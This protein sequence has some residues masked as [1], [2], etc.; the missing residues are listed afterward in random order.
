MLTALLLLSTAGLPIPTPRDATFH[1]GVALGLFVSS[2]DPAYQTATYRTF[3]E[4]IRDL[5][6]THVQLVVRG[7]QDD[8]RASE[9]TAETTD[10]VVAATL[11]HAASLG[12][13]TFVMPIVHLRHRAGKDWRGVLAPTDRR[14]WWRSYRRFVFRYARMPHVDLLAIGSELLTMERDERRWRAL[15]AD[16]RRVYRGQL[17]YSANWDH[18]QP[19]PFWDA[20][21]VVGVNAYPS[22]SGAPNPDETTLTAGWGPFTRELRAWANRNGH[23]YLLTELGFPAHPLAAKRPWDH[24]HRGAPDP[25]LQLRCWRSTLRAWHADPRLAGLYAWNWFGV[26]GP[27]DAGYT[28]R[29]K[30]AAEVIRYWYRASQRTPLPPPPPPR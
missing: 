11:A 15:A 21:D 3:L 30:P 28:P 12:L 23:R 5:G 18:Y 7:H 17:T 22:L 4:E 1:R 14:A 19:V 25:A 8:V 20:L 9:I 10:A 2:D 27:D 6:A 13:R 29:G 24:A 16:L 26:G